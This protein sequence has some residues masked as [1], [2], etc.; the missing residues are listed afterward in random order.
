[1][2]FRFECTTCGKC[3]CFN[4]GEYFQVDLDSL[5]T[6]YDKEFLVYLRLVFI[7]EDDA[8]ASVPLGKLKKTKIREYLHKRYS[9]FNLKID[10]FS[11][12]LLGAARISV[13][14]KDDGHCT[15]LSDNKCS[16]YENR[17][18]VCSLFPIVSDTIEELTL[19]ASKHN[20][21]R[22]IDQSG[23]KCETSNGS[24]LLALGS[25]E[26][27]IIKS[28]TRSERALYNLIHEWKDVREKVRSASLSMITKNY[29]EEWLGIDVL[30]DLL[31]ENKVINTGK[32]DQMIE[33]QI[34]LIHS[35]C[36]DNN[37]HDDSNKGLKFVMDRYRSK[38]YQIGLEL[39]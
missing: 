23:Y 29:H 7:R 28:I 16:I 1:M 20:L 22:L 13:V 14:T 10:A 33:N 26:K 36:N 5:I 18:S 8:I 27:K 12:K 31:V 32:R 11:E 24:P 6:G 2:T 34:S 17:P 38:G 4:N 39:P 25:E 35:M 30:L 15:K 9:R 19:Q 3:C 37:C 21:E